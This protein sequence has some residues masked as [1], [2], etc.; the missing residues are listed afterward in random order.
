MM[1]FG[2]NGVY[3][4]YILLAG[5]IRS[6]SVKTLLEKN[7]LEK[8]LR[9]LKKWIVNPEA[10]CD[11]DKKFKRELELVCG[12]PSATHNRDLFY[13]DVLII[14]WDGKPEILG[15]EARRSIK[16]DKWT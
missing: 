12:A 2:K 7:I 10:V 15:C 8:I 16:P 11:L 13:N 9:F 3:Q 5:L 6:V 14:R 4:P 1:M